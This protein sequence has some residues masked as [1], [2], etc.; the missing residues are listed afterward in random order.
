M[1]S[2]TDALSQ[3]HRGFSLEEANSLGLPP[4]FEP[5]PKYEPI[6]GNVGSARSEPHGPVTNGHVSPPPQLTDEGERYPRRTTRRSTSPPSLP[7]GAAPAAIRAWDERMGQGEDGAHSDRP[8]S[9]SAR[10]PSQRLI[11]SPELDGEEED[12]LAY[13]RE[14]RHLGEEGGA[15]L[16]GKHHEE[17][18]L[19]ETG[20]D[21]SVDE[22]AT[23]YEEQGTTRV[24]TS[25]S[26]G[27][28]SNMGDTTSLSRS[29]SQWRI[30][31]VP[32]PSMDAD[33]LDI[34]HGVP[35]KRQSMRN[36]G[37]GIQEDDEIRTDESADVHARN[38]AA[39]REVSRAMD[40]L[41]FSAVAP[42]STSSSGYATPRPP[43][44]SALAVQSQAAAPPPRSSSPLS[45]SLGKAP[46]G[47]VPPSPILPPNP[48]FANR[49][50]PIVEARPFQG[51]HHASSESIPGRLPTPTP[52]PFNTNTGSGGMG[53]PTIPRST[54]PMYRSPPPDYPRPTLPF[55]SPL[56]ASSASSLNGG[57]SPGGGPRT[58]SAVAFR[59]QQ[60]RSPSGAESGPADT[61][62]LA[63]RRPSTSRQPQTGV[64]S[65]SPPPLLAPAPL[66]GEPHKARL[67]VVN[68]DPR[69]SDDEEERGEEA[70]D[71]VEVYGGE[72]AGYGAGKYV[73]DLEKS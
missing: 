67:S 28:A 8:A 61:S 51:Y 5:V 66:F 63:L 62:P 37:T 49:T 39:A 65:G 47:S 13:E 34:D 52:T 25:V 72:N 11:S 27:A 42:P 2:I 71:Y 48:P 73:S 36:T 50:S 41:E 64:G 69:M 6:A 44:G 20:G 53:T 1:A 57:S 4:P 38:A 26:T 10:V 40:A 58:I 70:F 14:S 19:S 24:R 43:P 46:S 22:V 18:T 35:R 54:S 29:G 33:L 68:P 21:T 3:S 60:A 56:M 55:S 17:D 7:P 31:R 30:P 16:D 9:S 23:I 59:R 45:P 12:G 32:P 15:G